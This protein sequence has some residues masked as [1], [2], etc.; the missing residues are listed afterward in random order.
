VWSSLAWL[1]LAGREL[2]LLSLNRTR[3]ATH[4]SDHLSSVFFVS[5]NQ[6]FFRGQPSDLS[7][8]RV[9]ELLKQLADHFAL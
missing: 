3:C 4:Q 9:R 8:R 1:P 2:L 7:G 6:L 5:E